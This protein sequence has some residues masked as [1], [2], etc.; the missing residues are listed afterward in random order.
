MIEVGQLVTHKDATDD[1]PPRGR[2]IRYVGETLGERVWLVA[3]EHPQ[4]GER[5]LKVPERGLRP[6]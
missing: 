1:P 3:W 5:Q 4:Y 6:L 2:V